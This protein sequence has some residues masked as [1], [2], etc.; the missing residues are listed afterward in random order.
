VAEG[1]CYEIRCAVRSD[2][3]SPAAIFLDLLRTG[4]YL[5]DPD[6]QGLP[7]DAQIHD[8]DKF[9]HFCK[10]LAETGD[11]VYAGSVNDLNAG[12]WEFKVG[13]KRLS[14]Y[15]TPGD[16]TFSPKYRPKTRDNAY[17]GVYYWFPTFDDFI[18]LGH[19]FPKTGPRTEPD[20]I[21]MTLQVREEDLH[22]DLEE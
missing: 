3:T 14:F 2:S 7:D 15:D 12:I 8:Y 1:E 18:R 16:G 21:A 11:P 20:D 17:D 22:H 5:E 6:F 9:L 13:A 10:E 4:A 19:A